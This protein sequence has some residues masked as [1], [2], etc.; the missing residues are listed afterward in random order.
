MKQFGSFGLGL[1][2]NVGEQEYFSR[3]DHELKPGHGT[4]NLIAPC[5]TICSKI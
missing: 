5:P 1:Q 3:L 2:H 4:T